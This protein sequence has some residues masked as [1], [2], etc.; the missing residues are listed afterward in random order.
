M[1]NRGAR[2]GESPISIATQV[3]PLLSFLEA[4]LPSHSCQVIHLP[5]T[6]GDSAWMPP[7]TGSPPWFLPPD[8]MP[9]LAPALTSITTLVMAPLFHLSSLC[10]QLPFQLGV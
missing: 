1:E 5:I 6:L 3:Q 2:V 7:L 9:L 8:H 10:F 4:F